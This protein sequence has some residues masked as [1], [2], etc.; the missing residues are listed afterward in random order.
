MASGNSLLFCSPLAN[1][2]PASNGA[3]FNNRNARPICEYDP[4][5]DQSSLFTFDLPLHYSAGGITVTL[6]WAAD[7]AT[8]GD[9]KWGASFERNLL[10]TDTVAADSF[11]TQKTVTTTC[12][13]TA[14]I[15]TSSVIA[16]SNAEIDGML[17]GEMGRIMVRRIAS[18]AADTM[19]GKA[20]IIGVGLKET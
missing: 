17:A 11:A 10:G 4:T 6:K 2:P 7:T 1:E 13:G 19:A 8:S 15:I 14:G 18:D 3:T 16:F 9:V 5:T 12:P 20:Q